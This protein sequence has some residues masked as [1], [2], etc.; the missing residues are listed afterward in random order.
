MSRTQMLL[1]IQEAI[2]TEYERE[3]TLED[4]L[5]D[6]LVHALMARDRVDAEEVRAL[7][8]RLRGAE[9]RRP[10]GEAK[11][12]AAHEWMTSLHTRGRSVGLRH[13]TRGVIDA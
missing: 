3:P 8:E 1:P 12:A 9:K 6:P 2:M 5:A 11:A 13:S 4:V 7:L 10:P